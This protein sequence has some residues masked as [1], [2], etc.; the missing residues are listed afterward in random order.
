M[1][2]LCG[3]DGIASSSSAVS[4]AAH[5]CVVGVGGAGVVTGV[6]IITISTVRK[7]TMKK[8]TSL[9]MS[10]S[11]SMGL[12]RVR[13]ISIE[14]GSRHNNLV[15]IMSRI[16]LLRITVPRDDFPSRGPCPAA[17]HLPV[18]AVAEDRDV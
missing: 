13:P 4:C 12:M 16:S 15:N 5:F 11:L 2:V 9:R 8:G 10:L 18:L 7:M 17:D 14:L 3:V 1:T 6:V